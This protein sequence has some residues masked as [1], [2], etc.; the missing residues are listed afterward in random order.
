MYPN[1]IHN[2]NLN[3]EENFTANLNT[4]LI[5][6]FQAKLSLVTSKLS[7]NSNTNPKPNFNFT[8][9]TSTNTKPIIALNVDLTWMIP[10]TQDVTLNSILTQM[11]VKKDIS[12]HKRNYNTSSRTNPQSISKTN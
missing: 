1:P 10:Q 3:T 12:E 5:S 9:N 4:T 8:F 11:P 7:S 2:L 6:I